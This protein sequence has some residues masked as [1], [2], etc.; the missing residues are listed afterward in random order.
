MMHWDMG[1]P[2]PGHET[3]LGTPL[4]VIS[5]GH[6]WTPVQTS[7]L[8]P[9]VQ[10]FPWSD[11]WCQLKEL[12]SAQVSRTH[13]TGI[14]SSGGFRLDA[15]SYGGSWIRPC[16]LVPEINQRI[17][18]QMFGA[19]TSTSLSACKRSPVQDDVCH[20]DCFRW[21]IQKLY[22]Y[23]A[24]RGNFEQYYDFFLCPTRLKT[25]SRKY[26]F[27]CTKSLQCYELTRRCNPDPFILASP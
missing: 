5:G 2:S 4:L 6:H 22:S 23:I 25:I 12:Q 14:L 13:P 9:S 18:I 19:P 17:S 8:D 1:T 20:N 21:D 10:P 15:P 26:L 27:Q 16:S 24:N 7:S 3:W 11:T